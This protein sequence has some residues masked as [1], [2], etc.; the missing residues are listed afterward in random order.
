MQKYY[1]MLRM[2]GEDDFL[3]DRM[4]VIRQRQK[5]VHIDVSTKVNH[6]ESLLAKLLE[7]NYKISLEQNARKKDVLRALSSQTLAEMDEVQKFILQKQ[8]GLNQL[9]ED[10]GKVTSERYLTSVDGGTTAAR[11]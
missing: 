6:L 11:A 8:H 7:N 10:L 9:Y 4:V 5:Q 2:K 3:Y 1:Q